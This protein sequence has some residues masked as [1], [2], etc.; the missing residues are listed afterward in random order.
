MDEK[1]GIQFKEFIVLLCLI[2]LLTDAPTSP[3]TVYM[4]MPSFCFNLL[5]FS[6]SWLVVIHYCSNLLQKLKMCSPQIEATFNTIIEVF[7]FLDK[8]GVGKLKKKDVVKA[9]NEAS[10][11]EKS[12]SHITRSRFSY[13]PS[14]LL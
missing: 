1:E 10:P 14:F 2:Y 5:F 8:N 9:L 11:R 12:P 13:E 3:N 4:L 6:L 7:L